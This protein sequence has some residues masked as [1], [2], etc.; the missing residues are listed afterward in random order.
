MLCGRPGATLKPDAGTGVTS[1]RTDEPVDLTF[2]RSVTQRR[3]HCDNC[4]PVM[5]GTVRGSQVTST[6]TITQERLSV[7]LNPQPW[8]GTTLSTG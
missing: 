1:Q 4:D 8:S 6:H 3:G 5:A 2:L 7:R